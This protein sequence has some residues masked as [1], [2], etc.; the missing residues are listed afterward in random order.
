LPLNAVPLFPATED[1]GAIGGR[2]CPDPQ[3][4]AEVMSNTK[5]TPRRTPQSSRPW[6]EQDRH[7]EGGHTEK[8]RQ[9]LM[10]L[11]PGGATRLGSD[12]LGR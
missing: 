5:A 7:E 6:I 3:A 4:I 12:M 11:T 2:C 1:G 10:A 8:G 9:A